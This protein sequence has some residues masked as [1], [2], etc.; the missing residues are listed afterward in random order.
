MTIPFHF[1][2]SILIIGEQ[3]GKKCQKR[4]ETQGEFR[5]FRGVG[6]EKSGFAERERRN[7]DFS[8][9]TLDGTALFDVS[10]VYE[11]VWKTRLEQEEIMLNEK[12]IARMLAKLKRFEDTLDAMIFEKVDD[13]PVSFYQTDESLYEIPN[14][15][16]F[17]PMAPG[18]HWGGEGVYGWFKT[19]WQVPQELAGRPL[20]LRPKVGGYEAM[21]WV[22]GKPFGIFTLEN[23]N[24]YC[25]MIVKNPKAGQ[26]IAINLE[27]Y[28]WH[29]VRG[30]F[31]F[32]ETGRPDF[33][34]TYEAMEV[35]VK[36]DRVANFLFNLRTLNQLAEVLDDTSYRRAE[37]INTLTALH[38][39][40][41]YDPSCISR[42]EFEDALL[43]GQRIMAP[44]LAKRAPLSAP[45]AGVIGH[46][47]MDTAWLWPTGVT[48]KKCARTYAN[49]M[50]LME[51]YPEYK[52]VQSSAYHS[53]MI[54]VHYPELFE[55]IRKKVQE[56]R[57]EP[58]GSVWVECDC[59]ITSG[60]SMIRQFLWGQRFTKEYFGY[61][62]DA[63]W[64]PDTFG[65]SAA[66]PQIMKGCGVKYFLTTKMAW[67]DTNQFPYDTFLWKGLDGTQVLA[68][69]N[70]THVWPDPKSFYEFMYDTKS[71]DAVRQKSVSDRK[72]ISYGFGDGGGGPQF[73]MIEMARRCRDL[74]GCPRVE[75]TTVSRFM[76]ELEQTMHNP[77]TYE[78][79][80][81]LELHRGTLTNQH[82]IKRNNRLAEIA[83]HNLEYL[84]V[85]NA[86]ER[87]EAATDAA[88][89][90]LQ[91]E[92]L[93][94]QFHDI[95]PGTCIPQA[96][97]EA[98]KRVGAVIE[99]AGTL[100]QEALAPEAAENQ[101]TV[102][103]PTSFTRNDVLYLEYREGMRIAGEYPQQVTETLKG[104]RRLA[105]AGVELPPYGSVVLKWEKGE[106][107]KRSP[108]GVNGREL[109]TPYARVTF[110]ERGFLKSFVDT[111]ADR[112][113]VGEGYPFNTFLMAEDVPSAW[114][115]WDIDADLE[116]KYQDCAKFLSS[117][118]ISKGAVELRIRN[119]YQ[120]SE[121][122]A[123]TQH[124]VFYAGSPLVKF[125]TMMDWQDDHRFLKTA[126][127]TAVFSDFVRQ[128]IQFGYLKRPTTRNTSIDQ[129]K[130]E[131]LNHKYT[132]LSEPRYGVAI[133]NDCKYG[134]S[135]HGG[136]LR[137][138]LHKGGMRPDF[139]GDKGMH[140]CEYGFLPHMGGFSAE[141]VIQPAYAFNYH[142]IVLDGARSI[143]S[144]LSIDAPNVVAETVKPC[145]DGE[146]AFI[147]RLYEAE[148]SFTHAGIAL[149]FQPKALELTNMLEERQETLKTAQTFRLAFRPFEIK[150]VKVRY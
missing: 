17:Q 105:V 3:S 26:Q 109:V 139:R 30:C 47:H 81:Y 121:K 14:E 126:F 53:E 35:C 5:R 4:R 125:E 22:D 135:A 44:A 95:L 21:L 127:D 150:T 50:S 148:G 85:A 136:Q 115:N 9:G 134:I 87:K 60:E 132:D 114:D 88:Y 79:E 36:N 64:L 7:L 80:L 77:S 23:G 46:S 6:S 13:L 76:Q 97:D 104:G 102:V 32:E 10:C 103:N 119:R 129:A 19:G 25:D 37:I 128:E 20:F 52:F 56:G 133:L 143:E 140:Y 1:G 145:E 101:V 42:E 38:E 71:P 72:L 27:C 65:Y 83:L 68:H 111:E 147:L 73:E 39:V 89:R 40:L 96:H 78:G 70:K 55:R 41:Y 31:P 131:V 45:K 116:L 28:T 63:F 107:D 99:N 118:V 66:I 123:I 33:T 34:F 61:L 12:Q 2:L 86:V 54:R 113:L 90:D 29:Y 11:W 100:I 84:T 59:N 93:V 142:P 92:L 8:C 149:G 120:I 108:F 15:E 144:L 62:S 117:E 57:Y 18:S 49:Q 106:A 24:H 141:S 75:H 91:G 138:S 48:I 16:L 94:N 124:V 112:E 43:Q 137:L 146:R 122:S 51:Q 69:L 58:N 67:N 82:P 74:E 98:R 110:D 130:F